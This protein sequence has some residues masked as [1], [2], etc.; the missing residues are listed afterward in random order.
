MELDP[1]GPR[2]VPN[3]VSL[4]DRSLEVTERVEGVK[5]LLLVCQVFFIHSCRQHM[6][7]SLC[8]VL[9]FLHQNDLSS[10]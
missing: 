9:N 2:F 7:A 4:P 6:E 1:D 8:S 10:S 3:M 5:L